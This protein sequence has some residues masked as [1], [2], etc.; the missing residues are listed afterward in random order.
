MTTSRSFFERLYADR[1]DPWDFANDAYERARYATLLEHVPPGRYG[2]AYEPGC[3]VGV[4]TEQLAQR[5]ASVLATD[6]SAAAVA[7][8]SS[9]CRRHPGV[10]V[11][12]AAL[13]DDLPSGPFDLIVFSEIGYYLTVDA[14]G[15]LTGRLEP[16]VGHGG[17]LVAVHWTGS[18]PDHVIGGDDVHSTLGRT[19]TLDHVAGQRMHDV[20]R[21]GFVL[22]VWDRPA[23]GEPA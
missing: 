1:A 15:A 23:E 22:D 10:D 8:A 14:L 12:Q 11:R 21:G 5:C 6:I 18:S 7:R 13:P 4:L 16:L 9:R 20:E 2:R 19:L 3:S 17:R